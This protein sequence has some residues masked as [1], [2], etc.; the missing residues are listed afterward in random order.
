MK[1]I[2]SA[3]AFREFTNWSKNSLVGF[4]F[5][6]RDATV[7]FFLRS[8]TLKVSEASLLTENDPFSLTMVHYP[9]GTRFYEV[10][11]EEI[12]KQFSRS[13]VPSFGIGIRAFFENGD[14]CHIFKE[15]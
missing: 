1:E 6:R 14:F 3:E 15:A 5:A 11:A 13:K 12:A 7:N 10:T 2:S 8:A 9:D 4:N